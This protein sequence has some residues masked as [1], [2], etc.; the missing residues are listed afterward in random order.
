MAKA[1]LDAPHF[2]DD[3]AAREYLERI[4]WP[5]GPVCPKC[6][7]TER[8][9]RLEGKGG[10]K[11]T[12]GRHGLL[13]CGSCRKQFSVTVGT[14]FERSKVPLHKWLLAAYLLCSSKKGI[15]SH[16]LHRTLGVTYKTAWFMSHRIREAMRD[17]NFPA[18]FGGE[19]KIVEVD[20][21][22]IGPKER[23]R[24]GVEKKPD[25]RGR[26][27]GFAKKEKVVTLVE[28]GSG[29][30]RSFHV[31]D[32]TSDTLRPILW[33]QLGRET[34]LMTDEAAVYKVLASGFDRHETVTHS[35][36]EYVRGGVHTNTVE[37]YFSILRRGITG[38]YQ[39]VSSEHLKRYVG[40][41][42]F[43]YTNRKL[44]DRE[45]TVACLR[46]IE[47]KRLTYRQPSIGA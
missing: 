8:V 37:G 18:P 38:V 19:G 5:E 23:F 28:R 39:H 11:G 47:G 6:G 2:K 25:T 32:V 33:H 40:E 20:E 29:I 17:G 10:E 16:Q 31:P 14:L 44:T 12:Q 41:F 36:G 22:Y 9:Y 34:T 7:E 3:D 15:S 1:I 46:G 30:A 35:I 21:V 27:R 43:R 45:R 24:K 26:M 42:D 13:K 4:R